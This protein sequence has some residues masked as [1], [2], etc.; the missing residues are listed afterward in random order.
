MTVIKNTERKAGRIKRNTAGFFAEAV[1]KNA[2]AFK[3]YLTEK[4]YQKGNKEP[5]T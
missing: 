2:R 4:Y 5:N 3:K 1:K